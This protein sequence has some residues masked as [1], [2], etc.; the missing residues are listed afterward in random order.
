MKKERTMVETQPPEHSP[1][2][3]NGQACKTTIQ[4][5]DQTGA[6]GLPRPLQRDKNLRL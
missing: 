4:Y 5:D 2:E 6:I 3:V 1:S